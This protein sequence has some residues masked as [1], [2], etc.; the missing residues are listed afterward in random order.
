MCIQVPWFMHRSTHPPVVVL[1]FRHHN[2]LACAESQLIFPVSTAVIQ[3]TD[4]AEQQCVLQAGESTVR[5]PPSLVSPTSF[6]RHKYN[7]FSALMP[8][9]KGL[10]RREVPAVQ[11]DVPERT[12]HPCSCPEVYPA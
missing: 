8:L 10:G 3:S 11:R 5:P 12:L 2:D 6:V 1:L 9:T 4:P 7:G